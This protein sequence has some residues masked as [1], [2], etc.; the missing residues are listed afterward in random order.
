MTYGCESWT[1]TDKVQRRLNGVNS[2][3][4]SRITGNSVQS[5]A[6]RVTTS[7]DIIK[8]VKTM[9]IKWLGNILRNID[10]QQSLIYGAI[11]VHN[12]SGSLL[13]DAPPHQNLDHL[14]ELAKNKAFWNEHIRHL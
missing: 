7:F 12:Y 3:M 9:R 2:R 8:H 6:R 14:V 10:A 13:S 5:E 11:S 4:L 1:I